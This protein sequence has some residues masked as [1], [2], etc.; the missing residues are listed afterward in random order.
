[1][2]AAVLVIAV[3]QVWSLTGELPHVVDMAKI[4]QLFFFFFKSALLRYNL[5]IINLFKVKRGSSSGQNLVLSLLGPRFSS[6]SGNWGPTFSCCTP[7]QKKSEKFWQFD[8]LIKSCPKQDTE[9]S[10]HSQKISFCLFIVYLPLGPRNHCR[11][12]CFLEIYII[13]LY[14]MYPCVCL[15]SSNVMHLRFIYLVHLSVICYFLLPSRYSLVWLY[16]TI[17]FVI[18]CWWTLRLL[19]VFGCHE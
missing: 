8:T 3:A 6:W 13:K 11:L 14:S 16:H 2:T 12:I 15:L 17:L 4:E 7:W 5:C 18:Y 10:S 9:H 1:M 19:P